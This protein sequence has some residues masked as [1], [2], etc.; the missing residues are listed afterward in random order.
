MRFEEIQWV[1]VRDDVR[2]AIEPHLLRWWPLLPTWVQE[3]HVSFLPQENATLQAKIS[4]RNRWFCLRVTGIFLDCSEEERANAV[5]HEFI[6]ALLEPI[7]NVSTRIL[8]ELLKEG[9]YRELIDGLYT[10]GMEAAVEDLARGIG[11]LME[12]DVSG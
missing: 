5:R 1:D 2:A 9:P 8:D 10:D 7:I 6:H 11:R 12:N 4:H 3:F